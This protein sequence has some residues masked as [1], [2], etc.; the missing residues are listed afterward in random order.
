MAVM[1]KQFC[2]KIRTTNLLCGTEDL[3]RLRP[4]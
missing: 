4:L 2:K 3:S 1:K